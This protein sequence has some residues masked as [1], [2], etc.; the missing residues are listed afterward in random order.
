MHGLEVLIFMIALTDSFGDNVTQVGIG[1]QAKLSRVI[2]DTGTPYVS[3]ARSPPSNA[4]ATEQN[5][6]LCMVTLGLLRLAASTI[7]EVLHTSD[8]Q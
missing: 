2:I 4:N 1:N 3:F 6:S 5:K 7:D 8:K